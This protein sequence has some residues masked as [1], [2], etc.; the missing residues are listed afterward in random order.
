MDN[1]YSVRVE[2]NDFPDNFI[3]S[4]YISVY[5]GEKYVDKLWYMAL[6]ELIQK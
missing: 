5:K 3:S 6:Q 1:Y 4:K 2:K